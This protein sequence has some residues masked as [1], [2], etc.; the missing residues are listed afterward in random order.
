LDDT[1]LNQPQ[2]EHIVRE[3][4]TLYLHPQLTKTEYMKPLNGE[5]SVHD[6]EY[7]DSLS[8]RMH[9]LR[10]VAL[11][12]FVFIAGLMVLQTFKSPHLDL[13]SHFYYD[14]SPEGRQRHSFYDWGSVREVRVSF[15]SSFAGMVTLR[16]ENG[17]ILLMS[18]MEPG[19]ETDF[20]FKVPDELTTL[21]LEHRDG[22]EEIDISEREISALIP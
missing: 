3:A 15:I 7:L 1:S 16:A 8:G 21:Y 6:E 19:I 22:V 11:V 10:A 2:H 20:E 13:T 12:V 14:L 4:I 18:F 17:E 5:T 9:Y